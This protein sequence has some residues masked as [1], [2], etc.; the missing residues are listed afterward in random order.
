[1]PP[2]SA[3]G[4]RSSKAPSARG[5]SDSRCGTTG[6]MA[7]A[8]DRRSSRHARGC[9]HP[10]R[11]SPDRSLQHGP[12]PS[13]DGL[14]ASLQWRS[15]PSLADPDAAAVHGLLEPAYDVGG[16]TS[17]TWSTD[18]SSMW[19]SWTPMATAS[20]PASPRPWLSAA[21]ATNPTDGTGAGRHARRGSTRPGRSVRRP[22]LRDG[23]VGP[24]R[25]PQRASGLDQ[26]RTP[27]PLLV[28]AVVSFATWTAGRP[29]PGASAALWWRRRSS[30][31]ARRHRRVLLRRSR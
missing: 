27:P 21:T 3:T 10:H 29:F 13:V 16:D 2:G 26:R 4:C 12:A 30:A 17:T 31:R 23:A 8:V 9:G 24:T 11:R 5:C 1:M 15:P 18:S 6:A 7:S 20:T 14:P 28:G 19:R 22:G 25:S